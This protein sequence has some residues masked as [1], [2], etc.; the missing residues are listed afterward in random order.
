MTVLQYEHGG[1]VL[2]R[3]GSTT[4][5]RAARAYATYNTDKIRLCNVPLAVT[6]ASEDNFTAQVARKQPFSFAHFVLFCFR[7]PG[8]IKYCIHIERNKLLSLLVGWSS[9][10]WEA[11]GFCTNEN[12]E[13]RKCGRRREAPPGRRDVVLGGRDQL[14]FPR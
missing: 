3:C 6:T 14:R 5:Q 9:L 13:I 10:R 12:D 11:N 7:P 4:L 8:F 1:L 2:Q